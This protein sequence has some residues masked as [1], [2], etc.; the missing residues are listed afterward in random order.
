MAEISFIDEQQGPSLERLEEFA[1]NVLRA[2]KSGS[3]WSPENMERTVLVLAD[4]VI[5]LAQHNKAQRELAAAREATTLMW[6]LGHLEKIA[7]A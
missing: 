4:M 3:N 6:L 5:T 1:T 2:M 7:S